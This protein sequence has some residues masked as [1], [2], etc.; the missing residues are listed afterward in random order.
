MKS[1]K[2]KFI[3]LGTGSG[4]G[5]PVH[6]CDCEI[7]SLAR[8]NKS[9]IRR[10]PTFLLNYKN[11]TIF[12]DIGSAEVLREPVIS[13]THID[14][15]FLTHTHIDHTAGLFALRWTKQRNLPVY[16]P[17]GTE[18]VDGFDRLVFSP[19]FIGPIHELKPFQKVEIDGKI[20]ITGLEL[21][22]TVYTFGYY[23]EG[24]TFNLTHLS[25]TKGLPEKTLN[26][27]KDKDLD[28][29]I[30]DAM[31]PPK[32]DLRDHNNID[33]ALDILSQLQFD[34]AFLVHLSHLHQT[35]EAIKT[36]IDKRSIELS[37]D[38]IIPLD[39]TAIELKAP[40]KVM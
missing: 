17:I 32:W 24:E 39:G 19:S 21:N 10:P 26:F 37:G 22:H 4:S 27:L 40:F 18:L 14:A 30:I 12:I 5:I 38:V 9:Y 31:Y 7:C 16:Y 23:I 20:E 35:Y 28:I 6:M 33:D 3:F 8:S 1:I 15:I 34:K 13:S 2:N 36:R 29:V 25:D 11:K